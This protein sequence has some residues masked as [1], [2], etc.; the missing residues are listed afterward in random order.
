MAKQ[1]PKTDD[2]PPHRNE[3]ILAYAIVAVVGLSIAAFLTVIIATASGLPGDHF[4][5]GFWQ[6]IAILPSIGLPV[7]FILVFILLIT[8]LRRR[9]RHTQDSLSDKK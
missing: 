3:R 6:V 4:R 1:T 7:G 5:G 9:S 2:L 8:N